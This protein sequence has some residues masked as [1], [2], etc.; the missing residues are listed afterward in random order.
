MALQVCRN[1]RNASRKSTFAFSKG[2]VGGAWA[3][4]LFEVLLLKM[5][6]IS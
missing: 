2:A 1:L 3:A 5:N 4:G 6:D